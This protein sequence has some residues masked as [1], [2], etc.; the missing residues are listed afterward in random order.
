MERAEPGRP[1]NKAFK[2]LAAI[3]IAFCLLSAM[4][5]AQQ[6]D[7]NQSDQKQKK[8]DI[9]DAPS[10]SRPFPGNLPPSSPAPPPSNQ[11]PSDSG[12]PGPNQAPP[13]EGN[14]A[15]PPDANSLPEPTYAPGV[16]P[17]MNVKTVPEGG[18]TQERSASGEELFKL[19]SNVNQVVVPVM[20][21]DGTQRMVNGL[22]SRD[23]AVFEDGKKQNLNFFTTDPF[24]L[25]VAVI[26]DVG[27]QD[28]AVQKVNQTFSALEGAFSQFDEV[29]LY[30]YSTSVSKAADFAAVGKRLTAALDSLRYV[31][32]RNNGPPVTSGPLGPQGP[33]VN[34]VPI[35]PGS[36]RVITPPK[37]SHVLNDALVAAALDL[38]KR[39]RA[40]RKVIFVISDGREA[41]SNASY[42]DTVRVLLSNG[43]MVYGVAVDGSAVPGYGQLQ[44]LHVPLLSSRTGY[45]DILPKYANATGGEIFTGFSRDAIESTYASAL[46]E[47]RNQ[48]TLGY[49]THAT[50]SSTCRE[51]EVRVARPDLRVTAKSSY[52]PVGLAR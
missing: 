16:A 14:P 34:G 1:M 10:A 29:S 21:K 17:P 26:F 11:P 4:A 40:R 24:A 49:L 28:V 22:L 52:C 48:Y 27:M 18:A 42:R 20:V 37:E 36:S 33:T 43:I 3:L 12:T 30:T 31:T 32:G 6:T 41:R 9:P 39:D 47:A 46:G 23:F 15:S 7:Q 5:T 35:D 44:K 38:G 25:S 8:D 13:T 51:I 50:P 2:A 19:R 45:S